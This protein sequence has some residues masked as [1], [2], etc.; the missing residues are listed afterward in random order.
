MGASVDNV[1]AAYPVAMLFRVHVGSYPYAKR[2]A[3]LLP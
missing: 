2:R 1:A 3:Y